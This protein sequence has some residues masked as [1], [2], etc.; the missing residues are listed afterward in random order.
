MK[1]T[2]NVRYWI[3]CLL[4]AVSFAMAAVAG[5]QGLCPQSGWPSDRSDLAPDPALERGI[6]ENGLR[7]VVLRNTEPANRVAVFLSI[8]AGSLHETDSQ[9]G[10]A[11]YLEHMLFNGTTHFPPGQLIAFF[12]DIGMNFGGDTNA[13]TS[14]DETVYRLVLPL[15]NEAELRKGFLVMADFARGGLLLEDEVD[16]ERGVILAEKRSRDSAA[17]RS[18]IAGTAFRYQGTLVAKREII[19]T[20]EVLQHADSKL[21][22]QYYNS[23]YRPENMVLVVVGDV[24]PEKTVALI[25]EMFGPLRG[26]GSL[27]ACPELG[28]LALRGLTAF[29]H[30]EPELG[31]TTVTIERLWN[32]EPANDSANL[33]FVELKRYLAASIMSKRLEKT[34]EERGDVLT[35]AGY[36]TGDLFD[37]FQTSVIG[38][39]VV[40]GQWREALQLLEHTLRQAVQHGV[41]EDEL[42][43]AKKDVTSSLDKAVLTAVSRDSEQLGREILRHFRDNRVLLSPSQEKELYGSMLRRIGV[44][45]I[46]LILRNDWQED[47]R[48]V[49]VT[50][51]TAIAGKDPQQEILAAYSEAQQQDVKPY[52]AASTAAFPYLQTP[53]ASS[54]KLLAEK[55]VE[56]IDAERL[57]LANNI[58]VTLKKTTY[59]ANTVRLVVDFGNGRMSEPLPGL[60]LLAD[61]TISDSGT[62]RMMPSALAQALAGTSISLRFTVGEERFR[63]TGRA[64][65]GETELL[66]QLVYHLLTDPAL[67]EEAFVRS[68]NGLQQM[69]D[70]LDRDIQGA[71]AAKVE[72]FWGGGDRRIGLP[73]W[74]EVSGRSLGQLKDWLLPQIRYGSMEVA[75][76][77]DFEP[78]AMKKLVLRYFGGLAARETDRAEAARL[79]FPEGQHYET[80]VVTAVEKSMVIAAWL[81]DDFW[82]IHRT[83]RLHLLA[84]I[85]QERIREV[86]RERLGA[87]Y[88]PSVVNMP[89]RVFDG[90]GR[91]QVQVVVEPGR[92]EEILGEIVGIIDG[93]RTRPVDDLEL[94]RVKG[95]MLTQLRDAVA[96]NDYWLQSVLAGSVRHPEQL[97]WPSTMIDDFA[98]VTPAEMHELIGRY[99]I[100]DRMASAVIRPVKTK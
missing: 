60:A 80:K 42:A 23:W 52:Q 25:G 65:S 75:I 66:L 64:V 45:D 53:E 84:D 57:E 61:G 18:M 74:T 86:I 29:Y 99:L 68:R 71:V 81:T 69:Y 5:G 50:G 16:R 43:R 62:G 94:E 73:P 88:A 85:L 59:E 51:N 96:T 31:Q 28:S 82:D 13:H 9:R 77:G 40:G 56:A 2:R 27:P 89:S 44:A 87:S 79:S 22:R 30:H 37:T 47:S 97:I 19:G 83:R 34:E 70:S 48:L 46:N 41:T 10:V 91:M 55:R 14:F 7:Y 100:K 20:D 32:T 95:P 76:V 6:L 72:P 49:S 38:A 36:S 90:Y 17:Y 78:A 4:T 8:Q 54:G 39:T 92:E 33:Q 35:G 93:L 11:H 21:L 26:T 12:Q 15:G 3:C 63:Y 58:A 1:T 67:R 24:Q 98:G